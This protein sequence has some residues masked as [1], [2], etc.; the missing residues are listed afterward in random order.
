MID[1]EELRQKLIQRVDAMVEQGF[2]DE[3]KTLSEN[4][5]WDAPGLQAPGYKAFHN[6]LN[7]ACSL[8]EAKALFAQNDMQLAKRQRTWFKRNPDIKWICKREEA[9]DLITT[10]LNK[11]SIAKP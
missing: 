5:G 4:Y 9:I 8:E 6:Y 10:F 3:V 7:G 11:G 1:R 2:I